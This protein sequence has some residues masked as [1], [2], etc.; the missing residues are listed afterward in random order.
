MLILLS[1]KK[2][3]VE[4][5]LC[6]LFDLFNIYYEIFNIFYLNVLNFNDINYLNFF[7]KKIEKILFSFELN[8]F[9]YKRNDICSCFLDIKAGSGGIDAQDWVDILLKIYLKWASRHNFIIE[10]LD[11]NKGDLSGI[12]NVTIK[13]IGDYSY[14]WLRTET[15]IHR[16]VRHSPFN[17][18]NRRHTSFASVFVYPDI[19]NNEIVEISNK[20]IIIDTYKSGGAGGQHVNKTDSAVRITHIPSGTVVQCQNNR[21]QHLNKQTAMKQ[22]QSK[23]FEIENLKK[24]NEKK[25]INKVKCDIGWGRQIR[26]YIFDQSRVKDLRTNIEINNLSSVLDG[27]IDVFIKEALNKGY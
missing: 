24:E 16:L 7:F 18:L 4:S 12:K 23:L 15:G 17:S 5:I 20:D 3:E 6:I 22:L 2:K 13:V 1:F 9:F 21:S 11:F 19:F 25:N 27:F 26:S 14:G 8:K 10:I